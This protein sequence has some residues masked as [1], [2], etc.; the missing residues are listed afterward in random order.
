MGD[1]LVSEEV[2][3]PTVLYDAAIEM[4]IY[5]MFIIF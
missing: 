1:E 3:G 2:I 5:K 4:I